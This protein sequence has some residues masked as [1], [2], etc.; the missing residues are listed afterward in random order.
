MM[1]LYN[2]DIGC[3][4]FGQIRTNAC[5]NE[6]CALKDSDN[7]TAKTLPP[8]WGGLVVR[9]EKGQGS[10]QSAEKPKKKR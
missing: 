10:V 2:S 8:L 7:R 1:N 4:T 6:S 9:I 3:C 5:P